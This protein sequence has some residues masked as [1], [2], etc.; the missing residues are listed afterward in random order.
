MTNPHCPA[1]GPAE[2][3]RIFLVPFGSIASAE[4]V[5]PGHSHFHRP[6]GGA[7]GCLLGG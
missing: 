1:E 3:E 5:L 7:L 6:L 2:P 4:D